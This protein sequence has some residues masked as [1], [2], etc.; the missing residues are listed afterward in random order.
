MGGGGGGGGGAKGFGSNHTHYCFPI[1]LSVFIRF[2]GKWGL[3]SGLD[4]Y[5]GCRCNVCMCII[6]GCRQ[7]F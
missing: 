7:L 2:Y 6:Q 5:F 4:C 3:S 1:I